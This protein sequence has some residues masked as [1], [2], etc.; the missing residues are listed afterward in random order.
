MGYQLWGFE[1]RAHKKNALLRVFIEN[2]QGITLENCSSVSRQLSAS[3]DV[4]DLIPVAYILEVSSPGV[5]RV[6]FTPEQYQ[7]YIGKVLKVRARLPINGRRNFRG[8]LVNVDTDSKTAQI[9][10]RVDNEEYEI[11][12]HVVDRA[13]LITEVFPKRSGKK[14]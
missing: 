13:R 11:P 3:L 9:I 10:L 14:T 2:T 7:Q 8:V 4:D 12:F 5:D 6:L 1:Y